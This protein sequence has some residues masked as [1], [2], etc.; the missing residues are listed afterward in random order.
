MGDRSLKEIGHPQ[1]HKISHEQL[2]QCSGTRGDQRRNYISPSSNSKAEDF[3]S[4]QRVY[5]PEFS[6][7]CRFVAE[8]PH[9]E[10][11]QL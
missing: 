8:K 6:Q 10:E 1:Y 5:V 2:E 9:I 3:Y 4:G 11:L 7:N